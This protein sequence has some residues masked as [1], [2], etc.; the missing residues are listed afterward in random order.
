MMSCFPTEVLSFSLKMSRW[1]WSLYRR[2]SHAFWNDGRAWTCW[3]LECPA[4]QWKWNLRHSR[5][6]SDFKSCYIH[7]IENV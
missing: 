1:G 4:E 7:V 5:P 2:P 3:I 6:R